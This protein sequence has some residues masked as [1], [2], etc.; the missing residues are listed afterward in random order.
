[1]TQHEVACYRIPAISKNTT[2]RGARMV[3]LDEQQ[4]RTRV[5]GLR[6]VS[7]PDLPLSVF[8]QVLPP[9]REV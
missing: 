6:S 9:L 2:K 5:M 7:W 3:C 4:I 1:M 8:Y